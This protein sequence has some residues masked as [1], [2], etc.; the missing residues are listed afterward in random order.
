MST[1][2]KVSVEHMRDRIAEYLETNAPVEAELIA[3]KIREAVDAF[4]FDAAV[5]RVCNEELEKFVQHASAV[6]FK[7]LLADPAAHAAVLATLNN[8]IQNEA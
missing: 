5:L 8:T 4:D 7:K 2:V 3:E 6:Y 1:R